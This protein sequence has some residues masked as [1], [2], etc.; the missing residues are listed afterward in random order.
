V[1][2]VPRSPV[3]EGADQPANDN[4]NQAPCPSS[5]LDL[6]ASNNDE[7]AIADLV[8]RTERMGMLVVVGMGSFLVLAPAV[9]FALSHGI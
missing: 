3:V 9:Y 7:D 5:L 6:I 8:R 2:A 4:N 1:K